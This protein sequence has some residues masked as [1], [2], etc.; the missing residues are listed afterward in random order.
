MHLA[1]APSRVRSWVVAL[2]ATIAFASIATTTVG[3]G[4]KEDDNDYGGQSSRKHR[5]KHP[6]AS[7]DDSE[8]VKWET[9]IEQDD[10]QMLDEFARRAER[11]GCKTSQ[12]S[13][14]DG[15]YTLAQCREAPIMLV[16]NGLHIT[17]MCK[18]VTIADCK[19]LFGR[20]VDVNKTER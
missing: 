17:L 6:V 10:P 2:G 5:K 11:Y 20:I 19:A 15:D 12:D 8:I 1:I 3:C 18:G 16:K 14:N 7:D 4:P 13:T 9:D